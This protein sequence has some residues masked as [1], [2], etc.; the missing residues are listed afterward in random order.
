MLWLERCVN[1]SG[2]CAEQRVSA[3]SRI[4]GGSNNTVCPWSGGTS[5]CRCISASAP[6][7]SGNTNAAIIKIADKAANIIL[8]IPSDKFPHG[9]SDLAQRESCDRLYC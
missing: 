4:F 1:S 7:M 8:G 6:L 2:P 5:D 3:Q 9:R